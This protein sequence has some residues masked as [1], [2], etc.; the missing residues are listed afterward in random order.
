MFL[1]RLYSQKLTYQLLGNITECDNNAITYYDGGDMCPY[2]DDYVLIFEDEFNGNQLNKAYWNP[3]YQWGPQMN[4]DGFAY[5]QEENLEVSNGCLKIH[6]K[7]DPDNYCMWTFDPFNGCGYTKHFDYTSGAISTK[8][9]FSKGRFE[10]KCK[11]GS[12]N[13][14]WPAF[15]LYGGCNQEIDIFEFWRTNGQTIQ[16]ANTTVRMNLIQGSVLYPNC[17]PDVDKVYCS[18]P[19][20]LTINKIF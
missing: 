16:E 19:E 18:S 9:T 8:Q 13:G 10:I 20:N 7:F 14:T 15:W 1:P 3:Q 4:K 6:T 17:N 12:V 5:N 2:F 11:I